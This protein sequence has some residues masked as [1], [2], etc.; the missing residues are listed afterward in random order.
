MDGAY[1]IWDDFLISV[2]S[3]LHGFFPAFVRSL[4]QGISGSTA[5]YP[6]NDVDKEALTMWLLHVMSS[7]EYMSTNGTDREALAANAIRWCCLHP[8]HWTQHI[9]RK[10]LAVSDESVQD[11][12]GDLFEASLITAEGEPMEE[13]VHDVDPSG[14]DDLKKGD[15]GGGEES[16]AAGGWSRAIAPMSVPIGVVQ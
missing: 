10:L 13:V 12:W 6:E 15:F 8:G 5:V 16:C 14:P 2:S 11:E 3:R 9:G 7:D 4:L 1:L